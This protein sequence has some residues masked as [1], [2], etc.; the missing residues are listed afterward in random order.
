MIYAIF[1]Y[2]YLIYIRGEGGSPDELLLTHMPLASSV[3]IWGVA[4]LAV[5]LLFPK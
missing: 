1:R 3:V 2:L 5:L 4:V